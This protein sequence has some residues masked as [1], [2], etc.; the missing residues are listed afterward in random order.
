MRQAYVQYDVE[1]C[2][3][4]GWWVVSLNMGAKQGCE[5]LLLPSTLYLDTVAV[6]GKVEI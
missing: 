4:R 6:N 1:L 2:E 3:F 5:I